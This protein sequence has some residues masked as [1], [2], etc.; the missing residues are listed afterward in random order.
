MSTD[1]DVVCV[2]YMGTTWVVKQAKTLVP[3]GIR[4]GSI[5]IS[6]HWCDAEVVLDVLFLNRLEAALLA[7]PSN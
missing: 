3:P 2:P 1:S 6:G 4:I 7:M 5:S